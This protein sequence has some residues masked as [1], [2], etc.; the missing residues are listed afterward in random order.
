MI[1]RGKVHAVSRFPLHFMLARGNLD[2]FSHS[3]HFELEYRKI[4]HP[5]AQKRYVGCGKRNPN[6]ESAILFLSHL[7]AFNTFLQG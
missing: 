6:S 4:G 2:C 1:L 5:N 7:T 3:A